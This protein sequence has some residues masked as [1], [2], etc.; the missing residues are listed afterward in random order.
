[1]EFLQIERLSPSRAQRKAIY[2]VTLKQF[3]R[4][5]GNVKLKRQKLLEG[6]KTM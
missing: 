1:M 5:R 2:Q 3:K 4:E 6:V